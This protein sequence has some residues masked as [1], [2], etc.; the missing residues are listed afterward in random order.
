VSY[1]TGL[2]CADYGLYTR[3]EPFLP[4][5]DAAVKKAGQAP[6]APTFDCVA[7]KAGGG[8]TAYFGYTNQNGISLSIPY[9]S[10]NQLG[11]DKSNFR[12][13]VFAPGEHHFTTAV[14][15][16]PNQTVSYTLSPDA[17]PSTTLTANWRSKAC[18][19]SVANSVECGAFCEAT[20][21]SGCAELPSFATCVTDCLANTQFV[22]D[23]MPECLPQNSA[24]NQCT[25]KVSAGSNNWTCLGDGMYPQPP[26]CDPQMI[27][28]SNCFSP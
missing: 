7:P 10:K 28:L 1:W 20:L 13:S 27:A 22:S 11:L 17:S 25:S 8:Y 2:S 23:V 21:R 16:A 15:F 18:G 4:F 24:L 6:L 3:I 19:A 9:G 5:I 26:A 12:P 14:D